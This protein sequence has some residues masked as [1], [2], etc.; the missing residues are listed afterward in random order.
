MHRLVIARYAECLDWLGGVPESFDIVIYNKG[1]ELPA[2][3]RG[4]VV[5]RPNAGREGETFI[6]HIGDPG[7]AQAG[8]FTVFAQGDPFEHSPDFIGL[9]HTV[10][11]WNDIQPLSWRWKSARNIPPAAILARDRG[12][13]IGDLRIR[14][15][16]F[17]LSSWAPAGFDDPGAQWLN[18]TYRRLHGLPEGS[19]I[20]AHFLRLCGLADLA[21]AAEHHQLGRF[22]YGAAFAVRQE[23]LAAV[24]PPA[25]RPCRRLLKCPSHAPVAVDPR[26][27][28]HGRLVR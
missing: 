15:E 5:A 18:S 26:R 24:P 1:G 25:Q 19:N 17:S 16:I 10:D 23:N 3:R 28:I 9:L 12:A 13:F 21:A 22:A 6:A 2:P 7:T 11:R 4:R 20:A 14:P 27:S 8:Y